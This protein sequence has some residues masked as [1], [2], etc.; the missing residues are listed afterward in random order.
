MGTQRRWGEFSSSGKPQLLI[1]HLRT[2]LRRTPLETLAKTLIRYESLLEPSKR[3]F[4][5]YDKFIGFLADERE[6]S[7][8]KSPREHLDKL[9]IASLETD[10]IY[11]EARERRRDFGT[12]LTEIFLDPKSELYKQTIRYG[13][14]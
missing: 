3:L 11:V 7:D 2:I 9:D 12:A 5:A 14:F 8:G 10:P 13:V 1:E 4:D 6:V